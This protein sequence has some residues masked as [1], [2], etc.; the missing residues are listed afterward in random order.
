M[1]AD[2]DENV[3]N[4]T[5]DKEEN[6]RRSPFFFN[7]SN[8]VHVDISV[9]LAHLL[10]KFVLEC[11]GENEETALMALAHQLAHIRG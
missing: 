8:M 1:S 11:A 3:R 6:V 7:V 5:D 10:G 4:E 9:P 2:R